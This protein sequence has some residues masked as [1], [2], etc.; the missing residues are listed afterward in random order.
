MIES[1][2]RNFNLKRLLYILK[3]GLIFMILLGIIGAAVAWLYADSKQS[4]SYQA[5][6]SFYLYSKSDY[7]YDSS[8]NLSNTEI[9]LAKNL[10]PS[11]VAIM[12][13]GVVLDQVIES[14]GLNITAAQLSNKISYATV[15]STSLFRVYV[16]DSDPYRAMML[17][18]ALADISPQAITEIVKSG[19]VSVIDYATLPTVSVSSVNVAKYVLLGGVGGFGLV[20]ALC[21]LFGLLDTRIMWKS[22]LNN[23]YEIPIIGEI[24]YIEQDKKKGKTTRIID[25]DS[26]FGFKESYNSLC[27]NLLYTDNGDKCPVYVVT[28]AQQNEGKTLNAINIARNLAMLGKKT[29]LIDADLRNPSVAKMLNIDTDDEKGLSQYLAAID[30]KINIINHDE[31]FDIILSGVQP[32]NPAQLLAGERVGKLFDELREKYD[33]IIVD[34]PPVGVVSD[35]LLLS[36]KIVGYLLVV[37]AGI[38]KFTDETRILEGFEKATSPVAGFIFNAVAAK[39]SSYSGYGKKYGYG[40][41]YGNSDNKSQK[42]QKKKKAAK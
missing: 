28:S 33:Y 42:G 37:R 8:V 16:T 22:E 34:A 40:Y 30:N 19:G 12:K 1:I 18:N 27:T 2:I 4:E 10:V 3:K 14:V 17:A 29:V 23:A 35:A 7:L 39:D 25:D 38:S 9:T 32:P 31:N 21:M 41:G 13:S 5:V 11:Y 6:V 20:F 36:G 24:P 15:S 26:A